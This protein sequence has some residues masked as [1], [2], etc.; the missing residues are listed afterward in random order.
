[1]MGLLQLAVEMLLGGLA[2]LVIFATILLAVTAPFWVWIEAARA[3]LAPVLARWASER[4][5]TQFLVTDLACLFV[6]FSLLGMIGAA[7]ASAQ[8][9]R[10]LAPIVFVIGGLSVLSGW[11]LALV[12][13][14]RARIQGIARRSVFQLLVAPTALFFPLVFLALATLLSLRLTSERAWM[15]GVVTG[16]LLAALGTL[17]LLRA[18]YRLAGWVANS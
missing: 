1:M 3:V 8:Q 5:P 4:R 12:W 15:P 14:S 6:E 2:A 17:V 11:R 16:S 10:P 13:L 7:L 9:L 18:S